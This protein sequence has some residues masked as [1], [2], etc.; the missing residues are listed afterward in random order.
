MVW[1]FLTHPAVIGAIIA[2]IHGKVDFG[3]RDLTASRSSAFDGDQISA[4]INDAL[5]KAGFDADEADSLLAGYHVAV[6]QF[7]DNE[8]ESRKL[9]SDVLLK[10]LEQPDVEE[11]DGALDGLGDKADG[12]VP[13]DVDTTA[14]PNDGKKTGHVVVIDS[15]NGLAPRGRDSSVAT[16]PELMATL[17][18]EEGH[19]GK[20]PIPGFVPD[21]R[22]EHGGK[23]DNIGSQLEK[24]KEATGNAGAGPLDSPE[25]VDEEHLSPTPTESLVSSHPLLAQFKEMGLFDNPDEPRA[26]TAGDVGRILHLLTHP[27]STRLPGSDPSLTDNDIAKL[28]FFERLKEM[29]LVKKPTGKRV[30]TTGE[31]FERL[32]DYMAKA[33]ID[34]NTTLSTADDPAKYHEHIPIPVGLISHSKRSV[35]EVVGCDCQATIDAVKEDKPEGG[36]TYTWFQGWKHKDV[37]TL[38]VRPCVDKAIEHFAETV[39]KYQKFEEQFGAGLKNPP[40]LSKR[41]NQPLPV[42]GPVEAEVPT[43]KNEPPKSVFDGTYRDWFS[44]TQKTGEFCTCYMK[45]SWL[46]SWIKPIYGKSSRCIEFCSQSVKPFLEKEKDNQTLAVPQEPSA[47]VPVVKDKERVEG[48]LP[49]GENAPGV[50]SVPVSRGP[51]AKIQP[52]QDTPDTV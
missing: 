18:L 16:V 40:G 42:D 48:S 31:I 19:S 41:K 13:R 28:N 1:W 35:P 22:D 12:L 39:R 7:D 14:G 36:M 32:Q 3:K 24:R 26:A 25:R 8:D 2:N 33:N 23:H 30:M 15:S 27:N 5:A 17:T 52:E 4:T 44:K 51:T 29:G 38:C 50:V 46:W 9:L 34:R 49:S 37:N 21:G 10:V 45:S 20:G 47:N 43:V 11:V 6:D